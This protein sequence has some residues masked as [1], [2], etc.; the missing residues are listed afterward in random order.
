MPLLAIYIAMATI[1]MTAYTYD[2]LV[3]RHREPRAD[4]TVQRVERPTP[5][6]LD[7]TLTPTG[8]TTLPFAGGKFV[9]L[10]V[11]GWHEHPFSVAGTQADGSVR[12][13]IRAVGRGTRGLYTDLREGHPATLK[14]PYGMFDHTLGGPRQI[15]IA[16]GIGIAPLLGWLTHPPLRPRLHDRKPHSR[17]P[18]PGRPSPASPRRALRLPLTSRRPHE[19][20]RSAPAAVATLHADRDDSVGGQ[21]QVRIAL[22]GQASSR[23]W[24]SPLRSSSSPKE[25]S[26][27]I[28]TGIDSATVTVAGNKAGSTL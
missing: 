16:G 17:P 27:S 4:Y 28:G 6:I 8:E 15:W 3:L 1:G 24:A 26:S 19:I 7:L 14:G 20:T 10:R 13:T 22:A 23:K 2:E 21:P 5:D 9:Y 18:S 25:N 12:L 11:G